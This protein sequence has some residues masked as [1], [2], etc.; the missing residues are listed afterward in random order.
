M[1]TRILKAMNLDVRKKLPLTDLKKVR[2]EEGCHA[3]R[4]TGVCA[5]EAVAWLAG[6]KHSDTPK[7]TSKVLSAFV[8]NLNDYSNDKDRQKLKPYLTKLLNTAGPE[9]LELQ[10]L[11]AGT[12]LLFTA[13]A[14]RRKS[15]ALREALPITSL[16]TAAKA[17]D[18][19][20][21]LPLPPLYA[22]LL[23]RIWQDRLQ[24]KPRPPQ[25]V[26]RTKP[27]DIAF[28]LGVRAFMDERDDGLSYRILDAM[29]AVEPSVKRKI[30][31]L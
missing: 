29:L 24:L 28:E 15:K 22:Y 14:K 25:T 27:E 18:V 11:Y 20:M 7:C 6:E 2:L 1:N 12:T 3:R 13:V 4:E 21:L 16:E 5:M 19:V 31:S 30:K 17:W 9:E 8:Q 10:R 23:Q 26:V